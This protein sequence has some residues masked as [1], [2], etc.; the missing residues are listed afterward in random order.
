[1][2]TVFSEIVS[3][4]LAVH[5]SFLPPIMHEIAIEILLC[6]SLSPPE[7]F[8]TPA[9]AMRPKHSSYLIFTLSPRVLFAY[10]PRAPPVIS[11]VT[12]RVPGSTTRRPRKVHFPPNPLPPPDL[13]FPCSLSN[14]YS[15]HVHALF[16]ILFVLYKVF[17]CAPSFQGLW[18]LFPRVNFPS[19]GGGCFPRKLLVQL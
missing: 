7:F 18:T 10:A 4:V 13:F 3:L 14:S 19:S 6:S 2:R 8:S 12:G 11:Y 17:F 15:V 16:T 1:M 9:V 5:H